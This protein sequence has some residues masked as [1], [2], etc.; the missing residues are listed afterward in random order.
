VVTVLGDAAKIEKM[1]RILFENAVIYT[2]AGK[3]TVSVAEKEKDAIITITDTGIGIPAEDIEHLFKKFKRASNANSV[4][5]LGSGLGLFVAKEIVEAHG[6][7]IWVASPG[8]NQ[9]A[10]FFVALPLKD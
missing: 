8:V 4:S 2:P 7:R 6:G 3:I 5:V 10:R 9:G 1:F